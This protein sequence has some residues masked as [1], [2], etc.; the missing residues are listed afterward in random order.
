MFIEQLYMFWRLILFQL[1]CLQLI[2]LLIL[3]II[4]F[5]VQKILSLIKSHLFIFCFNFHYS[6]CGSK[7][8]LLSFMS[9]ISEYSLC[10]SSKNFIVSALIY[11]FLIHF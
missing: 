6:R 10:F 9:F 2:S 11:K 4:S 1:F 5:A 3:F 7:R 8:I